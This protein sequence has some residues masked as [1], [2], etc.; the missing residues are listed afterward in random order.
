MSDKSKQRYTTVLKK[1][2]LSLQG[3]YTQAV[4]HYAHSME[5]GLGS[6]LGKN[7]LRSDFS[8]LNKNHL[9]LCLYGEGL[10]IKEQKEGKDKWGNPSTLIVVEPLPP[11]SPKEIIQTLSCQR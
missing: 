1:E 5:I 2:H 3:V 9:V 10:K 7:S 8:Q 4:L 11:K 6:Y